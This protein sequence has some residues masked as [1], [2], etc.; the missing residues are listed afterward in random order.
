MSVFPH[1]VY[2]GTGKSFAVEKQLN[3]CLLCEVG[4]RKLG[5]DLVSVDSSRFAERAP[6]P[7]EKPD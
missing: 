3:Y 1:Q 6:E 2:A 4:N 7:T 5:A